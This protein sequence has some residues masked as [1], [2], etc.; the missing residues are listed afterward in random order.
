MYY[1]EGLKFS[2]IILN[3]YPTVFLIVLFL[4]Y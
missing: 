2:R 1:N 3:E 4:I